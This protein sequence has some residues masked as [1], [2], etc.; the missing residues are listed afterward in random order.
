[1]STLTIPIISGFDRFNFT[2][3]LDETSYILRFSWNSR[4]VRWSVSIYTAAAVAIVEGVAGVVDAPLFANF[5][6]ERLPGGYLM[7]QDTSGKRAPIDDKD[8]LG[9]RVK[10][11]Y[12]PAGDLG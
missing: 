5:S 11:V 6:D 4:E 12:I 8:Q 3:T 7:L 10:L 9:E 1:M 2:T